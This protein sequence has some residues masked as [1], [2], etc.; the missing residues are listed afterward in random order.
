MDKALHELKNTQLLGVK[1]GAERETNDALNEMKW[2]LCKNVTTYIMKLA[3]E[4]QDL[5]YQK[6][7]EVSRLK[8]EPFVRYFHEK[9]YAAHWIR[10]FCS[11]H[12][13]KVSE[14]S[15]DGCF[16]LLNP[17]CNEMAKSRS[18]FYATFH[19]LRKSSEELSAN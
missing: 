11:K 10:C 14:G 19:C 16:D 9:S 13:V 15:L 18:F 3:L 17:R 5:H 12:Y 2:Q 6:H 8:L 1:L 7:C 4:L